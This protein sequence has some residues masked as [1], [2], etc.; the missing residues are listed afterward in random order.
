M[1]A[2]RDALV[3]YSDSSEQRLALAADLLKSCSG[4]VVLDGILA[5]RPMA[6]E[7]LCEVVDPDFGVH[8][9]EEEYKVLVENASRALATSKLAH[10]LPGRPLRWLV[11]EDTGSSTIEMWHAP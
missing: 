7:I 3:V 5:L 10:L 8:R 4:V 11:V 6:D 2:Y 1:S 9:C